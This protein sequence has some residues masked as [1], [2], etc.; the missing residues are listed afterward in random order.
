MPSSP[1]ITRHLLSTQVLLTPLAKEHL[2]SFCGSLERY[3]DLTCPPWS[4]TAVGLCENF[5]S[6]GVSESYQP[7]LPHLLGSEDSVFWRC[8]HSQS[9]R[10]SEILCS[11]ACTPIPDKRRFPFCRVPGTGWSTLCSMMT[12]GPLPTVYPHSGLPGC[13]FLFPLP[14]RHPAEPPPRIP[15]QV[16]VP[17]GGPESTCSR[18]FT[19]CTCNFVFVCSFNLTWLLTKDACPLSHPSPLPRRNSSNS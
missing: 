10:D 17:Q 3:C 18:S 4:W 1:K 19:F 11:S 16:L 7:H 13:A 2:F 8:E 14:G 5:S 9:L 12:T 15:G 6:Q